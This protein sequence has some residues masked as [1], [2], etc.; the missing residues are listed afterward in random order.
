MLYRWTTQP[1]TLITMT[2]SQRH[3]QRWRYT[4]VRRQP[5]L[6]TVRQLASERTFD[7]SHSKRLTLRPTSTAFMTQPSVLRKLRLHDT[8]YCHTGCQTYLTR[9]DNRF[10]NRVTRLSNRLSNGFDN[11][12]D[13]RLHD[14]AGSQTGCT[15]LLTTGCIV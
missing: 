6:Q 3:R 15:T 11:L 13:V 12:L 14:T 4:H 1:T 2:T 8:T 9:F 10:E 7:R 5:E